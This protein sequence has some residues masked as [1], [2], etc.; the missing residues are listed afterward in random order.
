MNNSPLMRD[1]LAAAREDG[2]DV[3]ERD[4]VWQKVAA[5]TIGAGATSV[6][7]AP[8]AKLAMTKLLAIGGLIGAAGTA[9]GVVVAL[10]MTST[11]PPPAK[12]ATIA[13]AGNDVSSATARTL[14]PPPPASV[15]PE[16]DTIELGDTPAP[17]KA[18]KTSAPASSRDTASQLA[19]EARLVT[20]ARSALLA[21]DP[22]RALT[23]V[24]QT[25][26]LG[27][28]ALEPEEMVLE[29]RA[30]RA[31][32]DADGAAATEL[33]LRSRFPGHSAAR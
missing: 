9:L 25:H 21:G 7:A 3:V 1:L 12:H 32:G 14:A 4:A 5:T 22:A 30:L 16:P 26:K 17:H 23:L 24:R 13:P 33:R 10:N 31:L 15:A 28:R 11:E 8:A 20:E 27:V 2:P 29:A 18:T 19:E 6:A